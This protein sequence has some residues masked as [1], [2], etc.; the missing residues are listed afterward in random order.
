MY[1]FLTDEPTDGKIVKPRRL[2][3]FLNDE[4]CRQL[5][6]DRYEKDALALLP[7][8]AVRCV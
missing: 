7:F 6:M 4:A 2:N 8:I 1:I 5:R 3:Y